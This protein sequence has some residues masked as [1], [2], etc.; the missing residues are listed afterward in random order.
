MK[1]KHEGASFGKS[2]LFRAQI[3]LLLT[4]SALQSAEFWLPLSLDPSADQEKLFFKAL[5][6]KRANLT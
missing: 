4:Q 1:M 3:T 2:N 6:G 5:L